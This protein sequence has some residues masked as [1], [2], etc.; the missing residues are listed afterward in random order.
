VKDKTGQD[1]CPLNSL[2]WGFLDR[3]AAAL[4]GKPRLRQV[5]RDR[6]RDVLDTL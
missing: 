1:S 6:A 5:Y 3:N 4:R 2:Y